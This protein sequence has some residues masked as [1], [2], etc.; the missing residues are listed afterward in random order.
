[1]KWAHDSTD[2]LEDARLAAMVIMVCTMLF[3]FLS[4]SV[5]Y[6]IWK[7]IPLSLGVIMASAILI[8]V[9][10]LRIRN[11]EFSTGPFSRAVSTDCTRN[12][13]KL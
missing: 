12:L 8:L 3:T 4:P 6:D 11:I 2:W 7:I 1:M 9:L 13:F 10:N 5:G